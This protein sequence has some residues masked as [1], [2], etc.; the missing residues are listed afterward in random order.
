MSG[1]SAPRA[2]VYGTELAET[3]VKLEAKY[4]D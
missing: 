4:E 2:D 3:F 1:R